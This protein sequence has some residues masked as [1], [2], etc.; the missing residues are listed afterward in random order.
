M[1]SLLQLIE[2]YQLLNIAKIGGGGFHQKCEECYRMKEIQVLI[3]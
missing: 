3:L 2:K 1:V